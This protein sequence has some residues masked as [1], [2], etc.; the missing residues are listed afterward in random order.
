MLTT[1]STPVRF[2]RWGL[3][4]VD[5]LPQTS[6]KRKFLFVAVDNFTKWAEAMSIATI[7][8]KMAIN[9]VFKNIICCFGTSVQII[10]NNDTHFVRR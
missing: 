6:K 3:D 1:I 2:A 8:N 10:T 7:N 4:I 9:F 5:P